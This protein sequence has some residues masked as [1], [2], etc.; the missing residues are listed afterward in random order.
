MRL[1]INT[2]DYN[3]DCSCIDH[4]VT[5]QITYHT[6]INV[7]QVML[8]NVMKLRRVQDLV[9]FREVGFASFGIG[10]HGV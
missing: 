7:M 3:N 8:Y 2:V 4:N 9:D 1:L 6:V 5:S 10:L